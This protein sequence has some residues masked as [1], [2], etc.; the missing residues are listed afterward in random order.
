MT[1]DEVEIIEMIRN[2][3]NPERALMKAFE[4]AKDIISRRGND[5]GTERAPLQS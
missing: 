5:E 3:N 2:S 1:P 4:I